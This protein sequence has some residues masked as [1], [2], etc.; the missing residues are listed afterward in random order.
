[1]K[2]IE[3]KVVLVQQEDKMADFKHISELIEEV[4]KETED[5]FYEFQK[6][7]EKGNGTNKQ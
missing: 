4:L 2:L 1:M 7:R 5:F 6:Q 3:E